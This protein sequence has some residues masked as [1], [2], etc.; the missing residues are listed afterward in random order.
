MPISQIFGAK[1]FFQ[2]IGLS[3]TTSCGFLA[4]WQNSEKSHDQAMCSWS[5]VHSNPCSSKNKSLIY[6]IN[7]DYGTNFAQNFCFSFSFFSFGYKKKKN[8]HWTQSCFKIYFNVCLT[9][10]IHFMN[11]MKFD[12]IFKFP[13]LQRKKMYTLKLIAASNFSLLHHICFQSFLLSLR[14]ISIQQMSKAKLTQFG[15]KWFFSIF[16][17]GEQNVLFT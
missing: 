15:G 8:T 6:C 10:V 14:R 9:I 1:K 5:F 7:F 13:L 17:W 3:C 2:K 4:P 12:F 11:F 16:I